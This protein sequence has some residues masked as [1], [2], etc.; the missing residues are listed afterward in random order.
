MGHCDYTLKDGE[1]NPVSAL[2]I[3][4]FQ[5]S[6]EATL[7]LLYGSQNDCRFFTGVV[8]PQQTEKK[9]SPWKHRGN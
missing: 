9:Y 6:A 4:A 5:T 7:R 2:C 1:Q 8:A 3:N